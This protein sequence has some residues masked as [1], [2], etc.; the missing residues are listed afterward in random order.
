MYKIIGTSEPNILSITDYLIGDMSD[1]N[2][3]F[4]LLDKP[5]I[6]LSNDWLD[7]NFPNL[8]CRMKLICQLPEVV[9]SMSKCDNYNQERK[10]YLNEAFKVSDNSNSDVALDAILS[11]SNIDNPIISLHHVNNMIY[12]SNLMPLKA[13][14]EKLGIAVLENA[15]LDTPNVINV[16]AHFACLL[17]PK[18]AKNFCVHLDHGLKGVGTANVE[19]SKRDYIKH[20]FFPSVNLHLTAGNM[21]QA[22]TEMLLGPLK[23]RAIIG[24][25]PK[26]TSII[27]GAT[28]RNREI[29]CNT[30][31]LDMSLPIITYASAGE[32]S[33]EKPGGSLS[34]DVLRALKTFEREHNFNVIIKLKYPYYFQRKL[35]SN[36]KNRFK[37]IVLS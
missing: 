18:V 32:G 20:N 19:I 15:I 35:L 21:G 29:I 28:M 27:N 31:D 24:G 8:G 33:S 34:K 13:S 10:K 11:I 9:D 4:L 5:I 3:E 30:F 1:I 37:N 16:A 12:K 6:L 22:R 2:Y 17:H 14:A 25:Y 36:I 23:H 26:A 7:V